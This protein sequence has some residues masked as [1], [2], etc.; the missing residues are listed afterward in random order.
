MIFCPVDNH[1]QAAHKKHT[2]THT[3]S[4]LFLAIGFS[5]A[6]ESFSFPGRHPP[7]PTHHQFTEEGGFP[8]LGS[9]HKKKSDEMNLKNHRSKT[10]GAIGG[11][12]GKSTSLN[13]L[14]ATA[15]VG[16]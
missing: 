11:I 1:E 13:Y 14:T 15:D 16:G 6:C 9:T 7:P 8:S 2:H 10:G 12:E 3:P 4:A 5:F